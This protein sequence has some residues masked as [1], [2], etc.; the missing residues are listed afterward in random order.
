MKYEKHNSDNKELVSCYD[1]RLT[2]WTSLS[3][4]LKVINAIECKKEKLLD[5]FI[6][7]D[8]VDNGIL[9]HPANF[10]ISNTL[11]KN[12]PKT[13][14]ELKQKMALVEIELCDIDKQ[15][16]DSR[17][18]ISE[19]NMIPNDIN[20]LLY[21]SAILMIQ[22]LCKKISFP[23]IWNLN[24][25]NLIWTNAITKQ[26]ATNEISSISQL[27]IRAC[28]STRNR[29]TILLQKLSRLKTDDTKYDPPIIK[30]LEDFRDSISK[31]IQEL[32]KNQI[33][34]EGNSPRQLIPISI[35][36]LSNKN[37]PFQEK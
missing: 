22:L 25:R 6:P 7:I 18:F 35:I 11:F 9:I 27:I 12:S 32:E 28:L 3:L 36:S 10:N 19:L 8:K 29:E 37:N 31:A 13:W 17:Y 30:N 2:E 16:E 24:D 21:G 5:F 15:I 20:Q 1:L 34:V 4:M 26:L 14:D 33:S 23:W